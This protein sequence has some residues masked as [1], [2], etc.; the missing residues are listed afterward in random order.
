M[1]SRGLWRGGG[2]ATPGIESMAETGSKA[3]LLNEVNALV[4]Q[5]VAET[6]IS[7]PGI[8]VSPGVTMLDFEVT[9]VFTD[10][11]FSEHENLFAATECAGRYRPFFEAYV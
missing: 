6:A 10:A 4:A 8:T 2:L 1:G 5:G 7:G 11:A 3:R 9:P